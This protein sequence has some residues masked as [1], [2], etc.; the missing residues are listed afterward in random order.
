MP[1]SLLN[2]AGHA[3]PYEPVVGFEFLHRLG[4]VV[5]KGKAGAFA[6]TEVCLETEDG[7]IILLG[8]VEL[9][10]LTTEFVLGNVG[11]V[12]VEDVAAHVSIRTRFPHLAKPMILIAN[13]PAL[14]QPSGDDRGAGCG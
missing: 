2:L 1:A 4:R 14:T 5:D 8:L 7:D 12:G 3:V 11:A 13:F 9:A 6:A 10:E